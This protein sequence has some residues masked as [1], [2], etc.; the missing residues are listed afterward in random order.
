MFRKFRRKPLRTFLTVLQ[1]LLGSLAMTLA[2]STYL[3]ALRR[4]TAKQPDRFDLIAGYIDQENLSSMS[5]N[6]F[7]E[8]G[9]EK[10]LELTPDIEKAALFAPGWNV[11]FESKGKLYQMMSGQQ[12]T[13]Y[14]TP[15]YFE[16]LGITPTRGSVFTLQEAEE[17]ET[18]VLLSD[19][20]AKIIFG[21][22]DPIGQTLNLMP[23]SNFFATDENGD[24][25][26]PDPPVPYKVIGTFADKT[27]NSNEAREQTYVYF[28][29]WNVPE[30]SGGGADTLAVLAKPGK[31]EVA[32]A[33]III[34]A[35]EAFKD[36]FAEQGVEEGKE[37]YLREI[38]EDPWNPQM[39][40]AI[41]PTVVMFGLF[42]IVALIVGSIG[43]FSIMLVDALERERDTGIKR[44]LGATKARITREMTLEATLIAGLGGLLGVLLAALVIPWLASQ[45]GDTLFWNVSLRWQPLAALI[46]F[47][48]TLLL[49]MVLGF[50]PALRAASV[51]PVEALKG[52]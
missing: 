25:L 45:V 22:E 32:R 18:V 7:T 30:Y 19:E 16:L 40:N 10:L 8:E 41:D 49:G 44:A 24:P 11:T 36:K 35:K 31:G 9:L 28:P 21:D 39:G 50:F 52:V 33:Q 43:I 47:L 17:E 46:V 1:I 14:V 48:L 15:D 26:P 2:L 5:Y 12:A 20:T 23:D 27:G 29:I 13:G 42:G 4:Q 6:V 51:K 37:F 34:S 3:D 38:G